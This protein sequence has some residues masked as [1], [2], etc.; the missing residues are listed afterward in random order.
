[1]STARV[2]GGRDRRKVASA[3]PGQLRGRLS[4]VLAGAAAAGGQRIGVQVAV[5]HG[6][7]DV[8]PVRG[9]LRLGVGEGLPPHGGKGGEQRDQVGVMVPAHRDGAR[10]VPASGLVQVPDDLAEPAVQIR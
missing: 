1:M 5:E 10:R 3:L 8:G 4:P 6:Q 9:L 2:Q 7:R